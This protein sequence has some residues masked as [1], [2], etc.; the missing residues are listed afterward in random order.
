MGPT[1]LLPL[2]RKVV[3]IF[4]AIKKIIVLKQV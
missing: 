1:V 3:Q 2:G 4:I